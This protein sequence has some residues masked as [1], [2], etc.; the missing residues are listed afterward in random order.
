MGGG[1]AAAHHY[2]YYGYGLSPRG[3]GKHAGDAVIAV[4]TRSIPA[5]AG[6]TNPGAGRRGALRV[7]PRVG[8]GNFNAVNIL[9]T[10]RGLSPRGRG[11]R[12]RYGRSAVRSRSIPA[13]A[14]ETAR[15]ERASRQ[16]QVYPRVGG[17]NG[18]NE[19]FTQLTRGLSPR[20]RGKRL[21][22]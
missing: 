4:L 11:K 20:G 22:I 15:R 8:G 5:W 17:G 7:Y 19:D 16:I 14:G 12:G 18:F 2:A 1:N 3:R 10:Q 6:E 9:L 13:W 21:P